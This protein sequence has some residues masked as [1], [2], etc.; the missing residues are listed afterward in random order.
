MSP[1][2]NIHV[3]WAIVAGIFSL[4]LTV[5]LNSTAVVVLPREGDEERVLRSGDYTFKCTLKR[6]RQ[7]ASGAIVNYIIRF[8]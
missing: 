1:Q 5:P 8:Q 3:Q 4:S 2:G 7:L 6:D